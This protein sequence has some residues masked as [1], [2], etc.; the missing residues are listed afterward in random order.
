MH[1]GFP[2]RQV[3]FIVLIVASL[4]LSSFGWYEST[5]RPMHVL[6]VGGMRVAQESFVPQNSVWNSG[7]RVVITPD[8]ERGPVQLLIV[9]DGAIGAGPKE[10]RFAKNG[11][12]KVQAAGFMT[13]HADVWNIKWANPAWSVDDPVT[14]EFQSERPIQVKWVIPI[15]YNPGS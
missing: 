6:S 2:F 9:C 4:S 10:G 8:H 12:F 14:F 3:L 7:L 13:D 15:T 11:A 1:D 5:T